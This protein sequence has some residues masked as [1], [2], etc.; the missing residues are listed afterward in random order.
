MAAR[1]ASKRRASRKRS[2]RRVTRK[3]VS[4]RKTV[5]R[6]VSRKRRVSKKKRTPVRRRRKARKS[7]IR[8]T[9]NQ[10]FRGSRLKVKTTGQ[11][12]K[13]LM[14]NKRGKVVSKKAHAKGRKI[15]KK[16]GIDKWTSAFME[17]RK[18]LGVTG[19]QAIKKGTKLYNETKKI[20]DK[21]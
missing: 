21:K 10:V 16:N 3:R 20:Y 5:R 6:R 4:K 15:Y 13:D 7:L 19:F 2:T 17:A 1:R 14:K 8:G 9:R 11:T 18:N 12:K